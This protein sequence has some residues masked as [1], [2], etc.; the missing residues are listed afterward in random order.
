MISKR[1]GSRFNSAKTKKN[2][3]VLLQVFEGPKAKQVSEAAHLRSHDLHPFFRC[4]EKQSCFL[5][6]ECKTLKS[7][8]HTAVLG[9][10]WNGRNAHILDIIGISP[11]TRSAN[12]SSDPYYIVFNGGAFAETSIINFFDLSIP[13]SMTRYSWHKEHS[14]CN[15]IDAKGR[16]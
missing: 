11:S 12:T 10:L 8:A 9:W 13:L 3:D 16:K 5:G 7:S 15:C 4:G 14:S 2:H 1:K 6:A